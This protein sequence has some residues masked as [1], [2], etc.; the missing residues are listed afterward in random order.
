MPTRLCSTPSCPNPAEVR[1]KCREHAAQQR[2]QNRSPFDAFYSS[3]PWRIAR[4]H[5]LFTDPLCEYLLEDGS[6]CGQIADSV[7]HIVP[8]EEGG[9][10]RDP[11]NLM[12]TCR[13]HHSTIHAQ[14][15][16]GSVRTYGP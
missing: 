5:K 8:I 11:S 1:G 9:A 12:S 7:H 13:S 6:Q 2:K 15:R 16:G 4:R 14:R 3:K 10:R